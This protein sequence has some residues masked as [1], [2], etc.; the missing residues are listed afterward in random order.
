MQLA[1]S[2]PPHAPEKHP[3]SLT[4]STAAANCFLSVQNLSCPPSERPHPLHVHLGLDAF[5]D[6]SGSV[7]EKTSVPLTSATNSSCDLSLKLRICSM[8]LN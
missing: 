1:G 3:S 8:M 5:L 2:A 6:S 7:S 4:T